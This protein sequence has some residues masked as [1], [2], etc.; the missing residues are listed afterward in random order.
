MLFR[1]P[2]FRAAVLV[3]VLP[4]GLA[5]C[6]DNDEMQ[7]LGPGP[8]GLTTSVVVNTLVVPSTLP[9]QIMPVAGCPFASP[10]VS[11]FT[12]IVDASGVDL[13]LTEVGFQF[14]DNAGFVSPLTFSQNDLTLLFG[15]TVVTTGMQRTFGFQ[16]QF[17]CGFVGTPHLMNGRLNFVDR[18]GKRFQRHV[19]ARLGRQ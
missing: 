9:F 10:F 8:V 7:V 3:S 16:P 11:N 2:G 15:S 19:T 12:I 5:A 17:G 18:T 1:S 14:I 6:D 13:V 4:L